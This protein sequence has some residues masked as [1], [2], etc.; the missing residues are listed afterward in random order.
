MRVEPTREAYSFVCLHC[1]H[2]WEGS[3]DLRHATDANGVPRTDY[4][5]RGV[6][7]PSP[8]TQNTCRTC[9]STTIRVLRPGR[10][11]AARPVRD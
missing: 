8:L 11:A 1:G 4:Y 6:R 7:E 9:H 3:Y 10:V 2:G 5:V